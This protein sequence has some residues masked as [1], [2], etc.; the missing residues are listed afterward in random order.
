[1]GRRLDDVRAVYAGTPGGTDDALDKVLS[2]FEAVHHL[3]DWLGNDPAVSVTSGDANTL[4]SS[5]AKLK[6]CADLAIGAKHLEVKNPWT[7]GTS[8]ARNDVTVRLGSGSAHVFYV[9]SDNQ[10]YDALQ[11]AED[12]VGVWEVFL[13]GLGLL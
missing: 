8:I 9:A 3:K 6:I 11:L 4:I 7:V 10:E 13:S 12:A 2:F 5:S 1:V